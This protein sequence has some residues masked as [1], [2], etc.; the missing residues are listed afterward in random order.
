MWSRRC[1][2]E[3]FDCKLPIFR[4]HL[5]GESRELL[6]IARILEQHQIV[7]VQT[8]RAHVLVLVKYIWRQEHGRNV[9][10]VRYLREDVGYRIVDFVHE[11]VE[12]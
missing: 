10:M 9:T 1:I 8:D 11:I 5:S 6:D 7:C 12:N 2:S 3:C 4:I